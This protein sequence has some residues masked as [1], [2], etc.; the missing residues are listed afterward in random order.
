MNQLDR[1]RFLLTASAAA[2]SLTTLPLFGAGNKSAVL[3]L[4]PDQ[5]GPTIPANFLGLSYETQQLADP[6]FFSAANTGLMAQFRAL[7][8][9]GVLRLGGNTSDVGWFRFTPE[10]QRPEMKTRTVVGEPSAQQAYFIVPEAIH[11][12]RAFL[13]ATGWTCLYGL[14]LGTGSPERDAQEA[15]LVATVLG[16]KLEHFQIGNE[17]DLFNRHMRDPK[18]WSVDT[19]LDEWLATVDAIRARVPSARF[20][21]PDTS[22]NPEWSA[23]IVERLSAMPEG[24]AKG[25]RPHIAAI[26]H[27]YYFGGPPSN[28]DVNIN[29]LLRV[30][31]RVRNVAATTREAA[32]KLSAAANHEVRYR[33][34]EGNTC[35]R[36]GKPGVSDVLAAALWAAD[37]LLTLASLGYCGVNLHGGTRNQ[38]AASLGGVLPGEALLTNPNEPHPRPFYTPI[39]QIDGAYVQEPVFHGIH[40]AGQFAGATVIPVTFD[41]GPV[42]ATAY[43]AKLSTGEIAVVVINKDASRELPL[44]LAGFHLRRTLTAKSLTSTEVEELELSSPREISTVPPSTAMLLHSSRS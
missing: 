36:G 9:S 34:S 24:T 28:P 14:N 26:T 44:T 6:S 1:R 17:P 21:L 2:A 42:N 35:Y 33:M 38:V 41:P 20:G 12:L 16:P 30:D 7:T 39:A 3:T 19:Y 31:P 8:P 11:K 43:A 10:T 40:F 27:H 18:T 37:Y 22:G 25:T 29:R 15:E 4:H 32:E 13:D 5:P 23:R